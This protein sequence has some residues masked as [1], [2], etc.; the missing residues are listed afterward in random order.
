MPLLRHGLRQRTS[1][2][3][4]RACRD[5]VRKPAAGLRRDKPSAISSDARHAGPIA[6]CRQQ[7]AHAMARGRRS[8]M[9]FSGSTHR[10][11][12]WRYR[13]RSRCRP[14]AASRLFL[15]CFTVVTKRGLSS[16]NRRRSGVIVPELTMLNPWQCEQCSAKAALALVD[17]CLGSPVGLGLLGAATVLSRVA[18]AVPPPRWQGRRMPPPSRN[19]LPSRRAA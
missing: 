4:V 14:K 6:D 19:V 17:L 2:P 8:L 1:K 13:R 18:R 11:T 15:P 9:G 3:T 16:G 12:G 5:D 10:P 7:K